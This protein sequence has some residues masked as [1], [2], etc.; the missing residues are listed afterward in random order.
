M[1][2]WR[3]PLFLQ[4]SSNKLLAKNHIT[5]V[6]LA[7]VMMILFAFSITPKKLLHNL[8]VDHQ[9]SIAVAHSDADIP[10]HINENGFH[11]NCD[12]LVAESPFTGQSDPYVFAPFLSFTIQQDALPV[13]FHTHTCFFSAL[14]GPPA[15]V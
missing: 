10:I 4:H 8:I 12:N 14:R 5:K 7:G 1:A 11:C 2:V 6:V 13:S 3:I 15:T 9:D